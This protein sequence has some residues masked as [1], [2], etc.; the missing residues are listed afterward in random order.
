LPSNTTVYLDINHNGISSIKK[1]EPLT[2]LHIR[3]ARNFHTQNNS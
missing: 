3:M 1:T 2:T